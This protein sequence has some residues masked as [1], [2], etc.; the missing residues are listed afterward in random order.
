MSD[1]NQSEIAAIKNLLAA[2]KKGNIQIVNG[3]PFDMSKVRAPIVSEDAKHTMYANPRLMLKVQK[4]SYAEDPENG[5]EY[6]WLLKGSYER[7]SR[8]KE[9][10]AVLMDEVNYDSK[11][12]KLDESKATFNAESGALLKIVS[13]G[14][15]ELFE[16]RGESAYMLRRYGADTA[17]NDLKGK[18][19]HDLN[20]EV[21][22]SG[23]H[24]DRAQS[25]NPDWQPGSVGNIS[26]PGTW[27]GGNGK[28][29]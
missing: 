7:L 28:F 10:R 3:R 11:Y 9:Y 12:C 25:F 19:Q 26:D 13:S 20:S 17:L 29:I 21:G 6:E 23:L 1:L 18:G 27:G 4:P 15:F 22:S 5:V 24:V 8:R 2:K 16:T 14:Q